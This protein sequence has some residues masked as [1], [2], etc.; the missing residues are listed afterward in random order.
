MAPSGRLKSGVEILVSITLLGLT[1]RPRSPAG[2]PDP[3]GRGTPA[4]SKNVCQ[5]MKRRGALAPPRR[6]TGS[7]CPSA[8]GSKM[9]PKKAELSELPARLARYEGRMR[10]CPK[11]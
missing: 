4:K 8:I 2:S 3:D 1:S 7:A 6:S 11:R 10:L 9:N 5:P